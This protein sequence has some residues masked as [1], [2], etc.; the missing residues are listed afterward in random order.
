MQLYI[1]ILLYP[2]RIDMGA[3]LLHVYDLKASLYFIENLR[4]GS[5]IC[6]LHRRAL[7]RRG[8]YQNKQMP[9]KLLMME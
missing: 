3:S 6:R 1:T 4:Q 7:D 8:N 5:T 9:T 2:I